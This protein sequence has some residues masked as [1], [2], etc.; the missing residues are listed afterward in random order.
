MMELEFL[1]KQKQVLED[2]VTQ[3][4]RLEYSTNNRD[5]TQWD[6][7][8][9]KI[10]ELDLFGLDLNIRVLLISEDPDK[11]YNT[12]NA[13][14]IKDYNVYFKKISSIID[15]EALQYGY[16]YVNKE[17]RPR[18]LIKF[19]FTY[20]A[21]RDVIT[22]IKPQM[23][24]E[25]KSF[26][27]GLTL[28]KIN[29]LANQLKE[30]ILPDYLNKFIEIEK[31]LYKREYIDQNHKWTKNLTLLVDLVCVITD[32]KYFKQ[33]VNGKRIQDFHKRQF[34]SQRYGYEKTRLKE[35]WKKRK[36]KIEF[37]KIPFSWIEKP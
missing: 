10:N 16:D 33:T 34:I 8:E 12:L 20:G 18:I 28:E 14:F 31:E 5:K 6:L 19:L 26:Q 30:W 27:S 29:E 4:L 21:I 11:L 32:Y 7:L 23:K 36:P 1:K 9:T 17:Q 25:T 2:A 37:A 13:I 15:S 3:Y 35:T 24:I 22:K